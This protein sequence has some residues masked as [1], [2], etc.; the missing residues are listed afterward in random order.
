MVGPALVLL[1][2]LV[3]QP[4][5][6]FPLETTAYEL[7]RKLADFEPAQSSPAGKDPG[8]SIATSGSPPNSF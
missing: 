7:N 6:E 5:K 4:G 2:S 3:S 1:L 8:G